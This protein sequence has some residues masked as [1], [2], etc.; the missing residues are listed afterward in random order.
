M[1]HTEDKPDNRV[2]AEFMG[3]EFKPFLR[4]ESQIQAFFNGDSRWVDNPSF[5]DKFFPALK[6][7]TSWNRLMPVVEKIENIDV[8]GVYA[9][10][11]GWGVSCDIVFM[12]E[13]DH[14]MIKVDASNAKTKIEAVYSAVIQFIHW[15]NKTKQV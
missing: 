9:V 2:I 3:W 13:T 4:D 14:P 8:R 7:D 6:Y 15:Y 5:L 1:N 10:I 12:D 11:I